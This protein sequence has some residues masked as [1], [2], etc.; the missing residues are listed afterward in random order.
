MFVQFLGFF[1]HT[2]QERLGLLAAEHHDDAF[3]CVIVLVESELAQ[4]RSVSDDNV[5]NIAHVNRHAVLRTNNLRYRYPSSSPD[6]PEPANV[7]K[8]PAL[9]IESAAGIRIV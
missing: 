8:L 3:D 1:F 5:A 2:L 7:V 4:T 6:Q 9:G